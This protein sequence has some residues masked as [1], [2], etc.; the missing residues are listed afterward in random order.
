MS[1]KLR[2]L[3]EN[4]VIQYKIKDRVFKRV[5]QG[6]EKIEF[7]Y[8]ELEKVEYLGGWFRKRLM[9]KTRDPSTLEKMP[10]SD[11]G[12]VVMIV[13][14]KSRKEAEKIEAFVDFKQSLELA[15]ESHERW[16]RSHEEGG[17]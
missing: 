17:L 7:R 9:L 3:E 8:R 11:L 5:G 12:R 14:R 6:L 15:E 1:G 13:A 10:G 2:C 4:V 16:E